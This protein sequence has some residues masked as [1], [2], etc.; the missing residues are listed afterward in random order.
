MIRRVICVIRIELINIIINKIEDFYRGKSDAGFCIV[1]WLLY[2]I[3]RN[4]TMVA[5]C[6]GRSSGMIQHLENGA[7]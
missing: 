3:E 4:G 6:E 1:R 7:G 5:A 2:R